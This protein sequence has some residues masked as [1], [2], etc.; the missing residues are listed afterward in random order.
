MTQKQMRKKSD[1]LHFPNC[2]AVSREGMGRG[3]AMLWSSEVVVEI[4][5]YSLHHIDVV[6]HNESSS[7]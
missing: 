1:V 4:K 6:V 7:Y 3:L 5:S 2:F